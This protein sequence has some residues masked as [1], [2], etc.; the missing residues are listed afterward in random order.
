MATYNSKEIVVSPIWFGKV[1]VD[2]LG[3][4]PVAIRIHMKKEENPG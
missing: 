3:R 2:H 4:S 1:P